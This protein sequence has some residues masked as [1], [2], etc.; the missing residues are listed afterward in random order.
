MPAPPK[1]LAVNWMAARDRSVVSLDV[2]P[3]F[4]RGG[5]RMQVLMKVKMP[6]RKMGVVIQTRVCT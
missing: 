4:G 2:P 5:G 3:K 6:E 1:M